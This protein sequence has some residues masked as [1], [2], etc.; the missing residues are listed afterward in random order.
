MKKSLSTL[1]EIAANRGGK[2]LSENYV[3]VKNKYDWECKDGHKWSSSA[4]SIINQNSWCPTCAGQRKIT[5]EE[6]QSICASRG[7]VFLSQKYVNAHT[8]YE[9]ICGEGHIFYPNGQSLTRGSWCKKCASS[10]VWA[11]SNKKIS[12][13]DYIEAGKNVGCE[14]L[15]EKIPNKT[16]IK[17]EWKCMAKGHVFSMTFNNISNHKQNCPKC[18]GKAKITFEDCVII[19]ESRM[20]KI[21]SDR[22][23]PYELQLWECK[24]GH[25]FSAKYSTIKSQKTW[26]PYCTQSVGERAVRYVLESI[27]GKEFIKTRPKWLVNESGKRLELDG[28]CE[29]L[30]LAF[31]HN[32][33][34]HYSTKYH[35]GTVKL[36]E[37]DSIKLHLCQINDVNL[38][39]VPEVPSLIRFENLPSYLIRELTS[40]GVQIPA[41][42]SIPQLDSSFRWSKTTEDARLKRLERAKNYIQSKQATLKKTDW[43]K[44]GKQYVFVFEIITVGGGYRSLNEHKLFT[45]DLWSAKRIDPLTKEEFY[46]TSGKQLFASKFNSWKF[47]NLKKKNKD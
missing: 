44:K 46:P 40:K 10:E 7:G 39:V 41:D 42:A 25:Q 13:E 16:I 47:N 31:E 24:H 35:R 2:C 19:A 6:L 43:I 12:R 37:N 45:D 23:N 36:I 15:S 30:G 4:D 9:V 26:C 21:I 28:F 3:D 22:Y 18:Q 27:F 34:Q 1:Q 32:G 38:I 5:L 14:L 20:G 17:A 29:V 33:K 11:K 8:K